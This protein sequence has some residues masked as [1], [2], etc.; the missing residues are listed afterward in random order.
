[1]LLYAFTNIFINFVIILYYIVCTSMLV[2]NVIP[3]TFDLLS[4]IEVL[5]VIFYLF[6]FNNIR[7]AARANN[8]LY[9]I[10]IYYFKLPGTFTRL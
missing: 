8:I 3:T 2:F 10:V 7:T 6:H 1:M 4:S 5:I 9:I